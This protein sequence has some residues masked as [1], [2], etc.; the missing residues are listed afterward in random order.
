MKKQMITVIKKGSSAET[1][2]KK[3]EK[4]KKKKK[5]I[6]QFCGVINLKEDPLELQKKWRD[7][8]E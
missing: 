6:E 8:W 4:H 2:Q 5:D 1:V 7:E 3:Y